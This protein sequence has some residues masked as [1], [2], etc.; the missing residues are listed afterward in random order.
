[1]ESD[2]VLYLGG[3]GAPLP[4][5]FRNSLGAPAGGVL[6]LLPMHGIVLKYS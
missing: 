4:Q 2:I 5:S 6:V 1:M 3:G